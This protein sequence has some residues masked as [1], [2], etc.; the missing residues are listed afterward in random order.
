M[1]Q[2]RYEPPNRDQADRHGTPRRHR[3]RR[4]LTA[5]WAAEDDAP[6]AVA[7]AAEKLAGKLLRKLPPN[8]RMEADNLL[9]KLDLRATSST[10]PTTARCPRSSSIS[11]AI[12][13]C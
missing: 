11:F 10:P 13:S 9:L 1:R 8:D 3:R 12:T 5:A 7:H 4:S 6:P 2:R